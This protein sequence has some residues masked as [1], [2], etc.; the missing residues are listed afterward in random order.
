LGPNNIL[1]LLTLNKL[2]LII[3]T[4]ALAIFSH[5]ILLQRINLNKIEAQLIINIRRIS[6]KEIIK[7]TRVKFKCNKIVE[8]TSVL[9]SKGK[10]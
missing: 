7:V 2:Y 9:I 3:L 5:R 4:V 1:T 6:I 8:R 10:I